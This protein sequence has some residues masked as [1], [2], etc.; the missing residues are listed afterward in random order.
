MTSRDRLAIPDEAMREFERL[1]HGWHDRYSY[2]L[3]E[4]G[5]GD[6]RELAQLSH[7]WALRWISAPQCANA[8]T[9]PDAE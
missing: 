7:D 9:Q 5:I 8:R 6:W 2:E 4:G 3:Q 1:I